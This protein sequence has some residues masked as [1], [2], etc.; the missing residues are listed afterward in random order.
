MPASAAHDPATASPRTAREINDRLV[1]DLLGELRRPVTASRLRELTG[2]S[3]PTVAAVLRRLQDTGLIEMLGAS[4]EVL[5]GPNARTYGLRAGLAHVAGV[6][7]RTDSVGIAFA[8][9]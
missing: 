8:D 4:E 2:L 1:L 7:A 5:R 6:D 3:R 9:L